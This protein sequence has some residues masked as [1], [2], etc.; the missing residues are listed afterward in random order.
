M[1]RRFA[2]IALSALVGSILLAPTVAAGAEEQR[3]WGEDCKTYDVYA[4]RGS[5][6]GQAAPTANTNGWE[7]TILNRAF[8]VFEERPE[9]TEVTEVTTISPDMGYTAVSPFDAAVGA[10]FGGANVTDGTL[11]NIY[12]SATDGAMAATAEML[13]N[14]RAEAAAGCAPNQVLF[15]YSQGAIATRLANDLVPGFVEKVLVVGD[16]TQTPNSV[17]KG[18]GGDGTGIL[19][20]PDRYHGGSDGSRE[21]VSTRVYG[22]KDT[23]AY[24]TEGDNFCSATPYWMFSLYNPEHRSYLM[25]EKSGLKELREWFAEWDTVAPKYPFARRYDAPTS[26][27]SAR[28][29]GWGSQLHRTETRSGGHGDQP[30]LW[31]VRDFVA[32]DLESDEWLFCGWGAESSSG[33]VSTLIASVSPEFQQAQ[34]AQLKAVGAECKDG[35]DGMRCVLRATDAAGESYVRDV[36]FRGNLMVSTSSWGTPAAGYTDDVLRTITR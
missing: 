24:C 36:A 20:S 35:A 25:D 7:G 32:G 1:R 10:A 17:I 11:W 9:I 16:M 29:T 18:T 13:T 3:S 27:S 22:D 26:C 28:G 14:L 34:V 19:Y 23:F 21:L 30:G 6:E 15:G 12:D 33:R 31:D 8:G 5:G 4:L 2:I